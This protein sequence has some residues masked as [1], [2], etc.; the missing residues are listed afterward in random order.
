M[1]TTATTIEAIAAAFPKATVPTRDQILDLC[2]VVDG[3]KIVRTRAERI[4]ALV[5]LEGEA[6]LKTM[7]YTD[8][9]TGKRIT[10]PNDAWKL[11]EADHASYLTK[12]ERAVGRAIGRLQPKGHCPALIEEG[13]VT[14]QET[15]VTIASAPLFGVDAV[16]ILQSATH[17]RT[18]VELV[19]RL[20]TAVRNESLAA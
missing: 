17:S 9:Y 11:N 1:N 15:E 12:K 20:V 7:I 10:D 6:I 4:R 14:R 19:E 5:D 2:S 3:L 16:K 8:R 18:W 13:R